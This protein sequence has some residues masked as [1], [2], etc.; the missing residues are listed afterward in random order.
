VADGSAK[1]VNGFI[2]AAD[3]NAAGVYESSD[4]TYDGAYI[5]A[6]AKVIAADGN[7]VIE[8][9]ADQSGGAFVGWL[10]VLYIPA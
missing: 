7:M 9:S 2:E 1:D 4:T 10:Y 5:R 8:S 3:V 6:G